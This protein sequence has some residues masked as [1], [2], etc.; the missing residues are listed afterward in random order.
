MSL[1]NNS[2]RRQAN[3]R[4]EAR[5]IFHI[6]RL[7]HDLPVKQHIDINQPD[8]IQINAL[9]KPLFKWEQ[10]HQ[11]ERLLGRASEIINKCAV[12]FHTT[13]GDILHSEGNYYLKS[14]NAV[15]SLLLTKKR[16]Q[17]LYPL[18]IKLSRELFGDFQCYIYANEL[19]SEI[20]E[21]TTENRLHHTK[22]Q[23]K[24]LLSHQKMGTTQAFYENKAKLG[25]TLE[26]IQK[27]LTDIV[28]LANYYN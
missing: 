10:A 1:Q 3:K 25:H 17:Q 13:I 23:I 5:N 20:R 26:F 11:L 2:L 15:K 27:Y 21:L 4:S 19:T 14:I 7:E 24:L 28:D 9:D 8:N 18:I 16:I 12:K 22:K 6:N